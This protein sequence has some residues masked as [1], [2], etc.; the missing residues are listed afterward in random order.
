M[1]L[2]LRYLENIASK[3]QELKFQR[4]R[5]SNKYFANNVGSLNPATSTSFMKFC[6]FERHEEAG[7]T[8]FVFEASNDSDTEPA[9][10][11]RICDLKKMSLD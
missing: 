1:S 5:A 6:G 10:R 7:E 9:A 3:P 11:R 4:I 8:Y 2:G